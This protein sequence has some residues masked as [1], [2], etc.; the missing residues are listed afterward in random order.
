MKKIFEDGK[1]RVGPHKAL[2]VI[3]GFVLLGMAWSQCW[4]YSGGL[5]T[6]QVPYVLS[7]P[8]DLIQLST[9]SGD[10]GKHFVLT[11]DIDMAG[12]TFDQAVIAP[13]N[14][15]SVSSFD[16]Q[17][18]F[19]G[20]I[21][22][23]GHVISN[24]TVTGGNHL[25]LVGVLEFPGQILGLGIVDANVTGTGR[26]IG[27]LAGH[28]EGH[29]RQCFALGTVVGESEVG[30][31]VGR[32][33]SPIEDCFTGG[34]VFGLDKVGGLMGVGLRPG[35]VVNSYSTC[36]IERE[37]GLDVGGLTGIL[38]EF[39][40]TISGSFW[41]VEASG[42][43]SGTGGTGLTTALMKD[44][45]TYL[46]AGWDFVGESENGLADIW[47]MPESGGY[48][49]LS[50]FHG[51]HAPMP[52]D[53]GVVLGRCT[54][55]EDPNKVMWNGAEV[56]DATWNRVSSIEVMANPLTHP[57]LDPN[58]QTRMMTISGTIDVIDGADLLGI[59]T[60]QGVVCQ[61]LGEQGETLSLKGVVSPFESSF[62]CWA[63]LPVAS[64][65]F[66]LQFQLDSQRPMPSVLSQVDFY[67][68]VL[69]C[70]LLTTIDVPFESMD[71]WQELVPGFEVMIE[72]VVE[73]NGKWEYTV[74]EKL[75]RWPVQVSLMPGATQ[76]EAIDSAF[77]LLPRSPL[78]DAEA[79]VDRRTIY[80]P[81]HTNVGGT[82]LGRGESIDGFDVTTNTFRA[83][84]HLDIVKLEYTF[85]LSTRKRI[86][87]LTL[88]NIAMP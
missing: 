35:D 65:P 86:V 68:H 80:G 22:G 28:N 79:L 13:T 8:E 51:L 58:N 29:I 30:G 2:K 76:C 66:E 6:L 61:V 77:G 1:N 46:Q 75:Q 31:L 17:A 38:Y 18:S 34:S 43:S 3:V 50:I 47:L 73:E 45:Q 53:S 70:D 44:E 81:N 60:R 12:Y 52:F 59:D 78:W 16:D 7:S 5:G 57:P 83:T 23:N 56:F 84:G 82:V 41:D 14:A 88:T 71:T 21:N 72:N 85:A 49:E 26:R 37:A 32:N 24:L 54:L 64:Y 42:I 4:A 39:G 62:F 19:T 20:T 27:M 33:E 25:G 63:M 11:A 74:K 40:S 10:Y 67:V 36:L 87:P 48:P 69:E 55:S 9:S 15:P